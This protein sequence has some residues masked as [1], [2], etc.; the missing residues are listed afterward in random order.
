MRSTR[1]SRPP[2]EGSRFTDTALALRLL[3]HYGP[4]KD[5]KDAEDL[6]K[7]LDVALEEACRV[8]PHGGDHNLRKKIALKLLQS[9]RKG[10]TTLGGLSVVARTA[11]MEATRQKQKKSA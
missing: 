5:V 7:R 4:S 11:L 10:N 9:A 1:F 2:S 8:L 3:R 6:R